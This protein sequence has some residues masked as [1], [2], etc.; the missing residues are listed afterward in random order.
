MQ[1]TGDSMMA[2]DKRRFCVGR[3]AAFC[4]LAAGLLTSGSAS[5]QGQ[6][7]D[8]PGWQI[9]AIR[10]GFTQ[11]FFLPKWTGI[12]F[13]HPNFWSSGLCRIAAS[14]IQACRSAIISSAWRYTGPD[15]VNQLNLNTIV[16][17][18]ALFC[19]LKRCY[20]PQKGQFKLIEG[21][22]SGR[23]YDINLITQVR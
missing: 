1:R 9:S 19:L 6:P 8:T 21:E 3:I 10:M 12:R 17:R 5:A 2:F 14:R 4:L 23:R 7:N 13:I 22:Q 11:K 20:W 18:L 15:Q 16:L